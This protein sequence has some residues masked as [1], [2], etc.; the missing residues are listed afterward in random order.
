MKRLQ[1]WI[2][3]GKLHMLTNDK[4]LHESRLDYFSET[5]EV[6]GGF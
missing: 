1:T 6:A 4:S 5:P 3:L 2:A